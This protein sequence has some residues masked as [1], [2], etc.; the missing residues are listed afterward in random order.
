MAPNSYE[1]IRISFN[2]EEIKGWLL[3]RMSL[4]E[5]LMPLNIEGVRPGDCDR[6]KA[7]VSELLDGFDRID[8]SKLA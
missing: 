6:M 5:P 1:G 3:L 4:H 7:L 8:Q 2:S